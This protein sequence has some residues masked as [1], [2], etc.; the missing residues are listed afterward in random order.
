MESMG[1]GGGGKN[2]AGAAKIEPGFLGY[3]AHNLLTTLSD[4]PRINL[5]I[6]LLVFLCDP[7]IYH[8]SYLPSSI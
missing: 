5:C 7:G 3:P 1:G 2:P 8:K 4:L 6:F